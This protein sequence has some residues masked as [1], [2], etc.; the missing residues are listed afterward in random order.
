LHSRRAQHRSIAAAEATVSTARR[1]ERSGMSLA[2]SGKRWFP[3]VHTLL[4]RLTGGWIGGSRD[5]V[6]ILLITTG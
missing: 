6:Q 2:G 1:E 3:A 5:G 4:Y